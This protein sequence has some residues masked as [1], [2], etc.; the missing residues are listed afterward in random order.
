MGLSV[1]GEIGSPE[2]GWIARGAG[3]VGGLIYA[4]GGAL[5]GAQN[6]GWRDGPTDV[7]LFLAVGFALFLHAAV[8][9]GWARRLWQAGRGGR[10]AVLFLAAGPVAY[11]AASVIAFAIVGFLV[12]GTGLVL[13]TVVVWRRSLGT[14][15][16][17]ALITIATAGNL[18][19]NTET[20]SAFQLVAVGAIWSVLSLRLRT[21]EGTEETGGVR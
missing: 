17:R 7:E 4:V 3:A 8:R 19:W 16:D 1:S 6:V 2:Q 12:L 11:L 10:A 18:T 14:P 20:V 9:H 5:L 15:S 13:L 21:L